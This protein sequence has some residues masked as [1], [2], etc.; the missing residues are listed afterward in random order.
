MDVRA[1]AVESVAEEATN[2]GAAAAHKRKA[3]TCPGG[4]WK[5][6]CSAHCAGGGSCLNPACTAATREQAGEKW[7]HPQGEE[8]RASVR[9]WA[10]ISDETEIESWCMCMHCR[11]AWDAFRSQHA[12]TPQKAPPPADDSTP[13]N[14]TRGKLSAPKPSQAQARAEIEPCAYC[15]AETWLFGEPLP[16]PPP[17]AGHTAEYQREISGQCLLGRQ[18]RRIMELHYLVSVESLLTRIQQGLGVAK[19]L[20]QH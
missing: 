7:Y 16:V 4:K 2:G 5:S 17:S 9:A 19:S 11:K 8:R 15:S 18:K 3:V 13:A 10:E 6:P 14:R 12:R 1:M 20:A